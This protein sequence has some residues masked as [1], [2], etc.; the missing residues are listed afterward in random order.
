MSA[1]SIRDELTNFFNKVKTRD[2]F[3]HVLVGVLTDKWYKASNLDGF[4]WFN[5][6]SDNLIEYGVK[7]FPRAIISFLIDKV[8][9]IGKI[10]LP[11]TFF[12]AIYIDEGLFNVFAGFLWKLLLRFADSI[13][14]AFIKV[15][16]LITWQGG[17]TEIV[18]EMIKEFGSQTINMT[19]DQIIKP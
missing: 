3:T 6:I 7:S 2:A 5:S 10:K 4:P 1:L 18:S 15:N 14:P 17:F 12:G 11:E 13:I 9:E 16:F 19:W 8:K